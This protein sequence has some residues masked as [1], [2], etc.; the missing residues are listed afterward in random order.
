MTDG[1][2]PNRPWY[3]VPII[4][5]MVPSTGAG[6][7]LYIPS[8]PWIVKSLHTS[9]FLVKLT[10]STYLIGYA[11]GPLFF[12]ILSDNLG[13]IRPLQYGLLVYIAVCIICALTSNIWVLLT[14]RFLQGF[15]VGAIGNTFRAVITDA[16]ELGDDRHRMSASV[17]LAWTLGPVIAPFIGGYL[18]HYFGWRANFVFFVLYGV[19]LLACSL[20]LPETNPHPTSISVKTAL[21]NYCKIGSNFLFFA[22]AI[23]L[24]MLYGG[25]VIFNVVGPF[26]VQ[27]VMGYNAIEFGHIALLLGIGL[28]IGSLVNR[29]L[30]NYF[31]SDKITITAVSIAIV[32]SI[33]MLLLGLF[34][35]LNILYLI[36]P[37]F[38]IFLFTLNLFGACLSLCLSIFPEMA[39]MAGAMM[40]FVFVLLTTLISIMASF[41]KTNTQ[42]PLAIAYIAIF[43]LA[44]FIYLSILRPFFTQNQDT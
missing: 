14:M 32:A 21:R 12:G 35:P 28:F 10:I 1:T 43:V 27:K 40:G 9:A 36:A 17:T 39:G 38:I 30:L 8:L 26:L 25:I 29:L 33:I 37:L 3:L 2:K 6:I 15:A 7:D 18:Q 22:G 4:L 34:F 31:S 20:I 23:T 16:F 13:R 19:F 41:L 11:I 42:A 44:L 24:G 5:L